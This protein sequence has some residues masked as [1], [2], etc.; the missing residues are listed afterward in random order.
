MIL[1]LSLFII[2]NRNI[3]D[4]KI[5]MLFVINNIVMLFTFFSSLPKKKKVCFKLIFVDSLRLPQF[6]FVIDVCF[7]F[8]FAFLF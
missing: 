2:H 3:S 1:W 5:T 7:L 4:N 6:V 8:V